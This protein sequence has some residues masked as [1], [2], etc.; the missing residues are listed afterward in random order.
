MVITNRLAG[1]ESWYAWFTSS[2]RIDPPSEALASGAC[3]FDQVAFANAW[4]ACCFSAAPGSRC[5][6]VKTVISG[7][8]RNAPCVM[9]LYWP[10][11]DEGAWSVTEK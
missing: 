6:T 8:V 7:P 11:P 2:T 4:I 3:T 5:S 10:G 1:T 9:C